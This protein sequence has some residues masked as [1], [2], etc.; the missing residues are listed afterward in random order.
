LVID[1]AYRGQGLHRV[2]MNFALRD[3]AERGYRYAVNLSASRVT[4][5]ASMNMG[6]RNAGRVKSVY[7]RTLRKTNADFLADRAQHLPLV[8]RW[9]DRLSALSGRSGDHLF[10]RLDARFSAPVQW[11]D[12]GFLFVQKTPLTREMAQFVARLPRDGRIRHVRDETFFAWRFS[13]PLHNYRFLYAGREQLRGYIVLQQSPS[14]SGDRACI[15]DWEAE[16]DM[17]RAELLS[18]VIE[19]GQFPELCI[20]QLGASAAAAQL[21]D[22]HRFKPLRANHE[23]SI[24]VRSVCEDGLNAPWILG[25]RHLDD[26]NQWDLRMIYSMVG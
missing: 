4:V 13:N 24:L 2:I 16:S 5:E 6:W 19:Y 3:L 8:W 12:S 26:A 20:W 10:D 15:V 18:A 1:P 7:R 23:K 14:V 22:R 11:W 17:I 25:G 9:A 21:V